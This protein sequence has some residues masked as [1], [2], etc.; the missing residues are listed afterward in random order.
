M[1]VVRTYR[2]PQAL[3]APYLERF[4]GCRSW[5]ELEEAFPTRGACPVL[6]DAE[7]ERRRDSLRDRLAVSAAVQG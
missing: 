3:R 5:V 7:F 4:A 6:D 2:L 1:L